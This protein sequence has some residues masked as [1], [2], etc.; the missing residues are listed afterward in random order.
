MAHTRN[1]AMD[2]LSIRG[3]FILK[4][5]VDKCTC[6]QIQKQL[7]GDN[8]SFCNNIFTPQQ[9][10]IKDREYK[11]R[12]HKKYKGNKKYYQLRRSNDKR[13]F[14]E[15]SR[16][17][18]KYNDKRDYRNKI[19]CFS[20]EEIGHVSTSCRKKNNNFSREAMLVEQFK[21]DFLNVEDNMSDT[22]SIYSIEEIDLYHI[23]EEQNN[24]SGE[25]EYPVNINPEYEILNEFMDIEECIHNW[26]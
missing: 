21:M 19:T 4:H 22:E 12:H 10:G 14:L 3:N 16:H 1:T 15:K 25:E 13:P 23:I 5:L 9:Y 26:K 8:F 6:I 18:R 17:V 2:S 24:S 7:K 20:W 11:P